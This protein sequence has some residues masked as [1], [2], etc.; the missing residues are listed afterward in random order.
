MV[1]DMSNDLGSDFAS[2]DDFATDG[3]SA[4]EGLSDNAEKIDMGQVIQDA[5]MKGLKDGEQVTEEE[6]IGWLE[7][8]A[9]DGTTLAEIKGLSA[10]ALELLYSVAYQFYTS[11]NYERAAQFFQNLIVLNHW[12]VRYTF[13]FAACLQAQKQYQQALNVY[14]ALYFMDS[15]NPDIFL[16][17]GICRLALGDKAEAEEAF[18][19]AAETARDKEEFTETFTRAAGLLEHVRE[20]KGKKAAKDKKVEAPAHTQAKKK[21]TV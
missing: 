4:W 1:G 2:D 19:M 10:D 13:G 7:K 12:D 16:N 18:F 9:E 17:A 20:A 3:D 11:G 21:A 15:K 14:S 5:L 8:I 6:V